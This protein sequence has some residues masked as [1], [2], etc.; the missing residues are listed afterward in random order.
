MCPGGG[1]GG[2]GDGVEQP[3][4]IFTESR[5]DFQKVKPPFVLGEGNLVL[6]QGINK[7]AH[8][9]WGSPSRIK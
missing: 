2:Q 1:R 4:N 8:E 9:G 7:A 3:R 6:P 5:K